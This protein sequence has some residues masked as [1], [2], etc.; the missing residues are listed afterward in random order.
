MDIFI[1]EMVERKRTATHILAV[2]GLFAACMLLG[3]I[4]FFIL[5]PMFPVASSL[6][7]MVVAFAF[8]LAYKLAVSMNVE[9][10][11]S[12]VN[13]EIDVDKIMNRNNRKRVATLNIRKTDDF[14]KAA[15]NRDYTKYVTDAAIKKIYACRER[16]AEDCYFAVYEQGGVRTMLV[17]SPSEKIVELIEKMRPKKF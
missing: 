1:E 7:F 3:Y 9:Y 10:E 11:Y 8:Y 12:M 5:M 2:L 14:G 16:N 13:S 6:I 15:G 17:F 4:G